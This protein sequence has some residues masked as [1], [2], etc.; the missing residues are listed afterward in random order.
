MKYKFKAKHKKRLTNNKIQGKIGII[1]G[2]LIISLTVFLLVKFNKGITNNLE[3]FSKEELERVMN[4]L[5]TDRLTNDILNKDSLKD[6]LIIK[7]NDKK[8]IL[9]V[10]FNLDN[11]YKILDV[12]SDTLTNSYKMIE[13]GT[14]EVGYLD[15]SLSH[16]T[17]SMILNIPIGSL[18]KGGYFYN[19]GPKIPV[20]IN[21]IGTVLTNLETK[22]TNYGFNNA[23]VE[24]FVYIKFTNNIMMPF[25]DKKLT[26][27]YKN[28]I[29]SMMIEGEVP[30]FY[31][32]V[33][34]KDSAIIEKK[35]E[36]D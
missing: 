18:F 6:I 22:I 16:K 28:V 25:K 17:N 24:V 26:L 19:V 33:I 9:Y 10:D 14:I 7:E 21:F 30:S 11:A 32:G 31:N 3:E 29:A 23:L 27:E 4:Y 1:T 15:K 34:E 5:V 36:E 8:E 13:D 12:V 20:K 2:I 35:I